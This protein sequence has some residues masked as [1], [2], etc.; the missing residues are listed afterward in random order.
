MAAYPWVVPY[1][2]QGQEIDD[3]P[4]LERWFEAMK[5]RP[6]VARACA[7]GEGLRNEGMTEEAKKILFGQ[8]AASTAPEA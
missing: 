2:N 6:A 4:N 5:A 3:F 7:K 8:T 1:K